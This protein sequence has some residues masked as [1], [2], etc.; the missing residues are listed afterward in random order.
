VTYKD[1]TEAL[2]NSY[3]D[4]HLE[5]ALN[6]Q[7]KR[8]NQLAGESLEEFATATNQLAHR[9]NIELPKH[10]I[11]KEATCAFANRVREQDIIQQLLL[12]G[13]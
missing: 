5:A 1:V 8:R 11:S 13:K 10:L 7:L 9:T 6:S 2:E 3:S 4:H 12:G